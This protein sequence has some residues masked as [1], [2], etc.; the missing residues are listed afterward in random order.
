MIS[1]E[2][3]RGTR[4]ASTPNCARSLGNVRERGSDTATLK[5]LGR[6][7]LAH[8]G[9]A[10]CEAAVTHS[11]FES[12]VDLHVGFGARSLP[13]M[14]RSM[15]PSAQRTGMSSVRRKVMSTG[16][17]RTREDTAVL[18]SGNESRL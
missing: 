13:V 9:D 12:L 17:S 3:E 11:E 16:I 18:T 8:F 7:D 6:L 2:P 1:T 4:C 15:A 14:P 10:E 5:C